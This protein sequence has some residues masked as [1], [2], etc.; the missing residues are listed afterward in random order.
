MLSLGMVGALSIVRFRSPIKNAMDLGYLF[1][2]VAIGIAFASGKLM[3]A[4]IIVGLLFLILNY[5]VNSSLLDFENADK[6]QAYDSYSVV[7]DL[8]QSVKS[9]SDAAL[10][11]EKFNPKSFMLREQ[12]LEMHINSGLY[13]LSE[14]ESVLKEVIN[15][16]I[17]SITAY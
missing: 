15:L 9:F 16:K 4:L 7:V 17:L 10:V 14:I 8:S 6:T 13:D 1:F 11:I 12:V 3:V 5:L 2:S